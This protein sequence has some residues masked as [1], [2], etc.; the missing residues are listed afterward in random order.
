MENIINVAN[1]IMATKNMTI[2]KVQKIMY[3]AYS[4]YLAQNNDEYS[5]NMNKL[6]EAEFEVWK[7]GPV[8]RKINS[9]IKYFSNI[10]K[11]CLN[12]NEVKFENIKNKIFLDRIIK[13]Y[14]KYSGHEL[15]KM[16][17]EQPLLSS[18][19]LLSKEKRIK[20]QAYVYPRLCVTNSSVIIEDKAIYEYFRKKYR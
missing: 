6:F 19:F 2:R 18:C 1:Y 5:D 9:Y 4:I 11:S 8:I 14:N 12:K 13:E 16:T 3:Y 10:D 17:K 7:H 15:E 20:E